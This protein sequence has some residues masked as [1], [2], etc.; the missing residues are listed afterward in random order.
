M[1]RR[2]R[3]AIG[4]KNSLM[5]DEE[6]SKYKYSYKNLD[7]FSTNIQTIYT[8]QPKSKFTDTIDEFLDLEHWKSNITKLYINSNLSIVVFIYYIIKIKVYQN[9]MQ[10]ILQ[11]LLIIKQKNQMHL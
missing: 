7:K 2:K 11:L 3:R 5:L 1:R 9:Q 4:N 6:I 10:E 8:N